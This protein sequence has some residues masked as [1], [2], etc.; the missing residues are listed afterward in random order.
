MNKMIFIA[1]LMFYEQSYEHYLLIVKSRR[2]ED[3]D[4]LYKYYIYHFNFSRYFYFC[5]GKFIAV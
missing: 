5:H 3:I 1:K 2:V 4:G